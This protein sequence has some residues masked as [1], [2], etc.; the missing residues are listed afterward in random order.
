[1]VQSEYDDELRWELVA[2]SKRNKKIKLKITAN[3]G[4]GCCLDYTI[5]TQRQL[6][7]AEQFKIIAATFSNSQDLD[8]IVSRL[9]LE[10]TFYLV[11]PM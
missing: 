9:S 2:R 3:N 4:F 6:C 5:I 10:I 7:L 11:L 1:M 8:V